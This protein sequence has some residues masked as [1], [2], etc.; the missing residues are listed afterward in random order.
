MTSNFVQDSRMSGRWLRGTGF[1]LPA[2]VLRGI[3]M[4][5]P[6][7]AEGPAPDFKLRTDADEMWVSAGRIAVTS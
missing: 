5:A 4:A 3:A 2:F 1:L 7:R 6:A